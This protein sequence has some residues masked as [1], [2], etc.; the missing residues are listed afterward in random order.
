MGSGVE[1]ESFCTGLQDMGPCADGFCSA[2]ASE[3]TVHA[4]HLDCERLPRISHCTM[5]RLFGAK[6]TAPKPTL[7]GAIA[8]VCNPH[9]P[10][11]DL[12]SEADRTRWT[13][14]SRPWMSNSPN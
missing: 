11:A 8:N 13:A 4:Y 9:P 5:N 12:K 1:S 14:G 2:Q 7:A 10:D 6:N 3:A